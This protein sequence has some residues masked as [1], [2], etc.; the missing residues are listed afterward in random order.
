MGGVDAPIGA[1]FGMGLC[2]FLTL[3]IMGLVRRARPGP[4]GLLLSILMM[5]VIGGV[6]WLGIVALGASPVPQT[7]RPM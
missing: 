4:R 1:L 3:F 2:T 7:Y 6:S 5:A